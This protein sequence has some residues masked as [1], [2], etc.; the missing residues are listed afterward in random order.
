M[1]QKNK[2]LR[3]SADPKNIHHLHPG[4]PP[5]PPPDAG[6][7][8]RRPEKAVDFRRHHRYRGHLP[9]PLGHAARVRAAPP[10]ADAVRCSLTLLP[11]AGR[12]PRPPSPAAV[13]VA[14]CLFGRPR[15]GARRFPGGAGG[16]PVY[17]DEE[18][19]GGGWAGREG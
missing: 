2:R 17:P 11:F 10:F 16:T 18:A 4:T 1:Q 7:L 8:P 3:S 12:A 13:L 5:P 15:R 6:D 9:A 19:G 14:A